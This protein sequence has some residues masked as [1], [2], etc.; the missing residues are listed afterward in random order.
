MRVVLVIPIFNEA[1]VLPQLLGRLEALRVRLSSHAL[2]VVFIDDGCRD[3]SA[4]L[5]AAHPGCIAPAPWLHL[6]RLSRNFG[7]Q[8]ALSAGLVHAATLAP[9][10]VVTLD[11]DLQDPP[12]VIPDLLDAHARGADVVLAVRR[13]RQERGLRRMGFDLFHKLFGSVVDQPVERNTGT[14]GLLSRDALDAFLQLRERH[15]FFPGLRSWIGFTRAEVA[16]D[17]QERAAGEPAVTFRKLVRYALDGVF[18]FSHLPLRLVTYAGLFSAGVG[19]AVAIFFA[20]KRLLGLES[21]FTGF[22]T[23]VTLVLFLGGVQLVAI[24]ILGEYLGRIYDE[25]KQR[26]HFIVRPK[27]PTDPSAPSA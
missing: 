11:A 17:R 22:T 13:S 7:H 14:F 16:Y 24:G 6:V 1:L 19:F 27:R 3:Q 2:E 9:D 5:V 8:A 10:V 18:S 23:L 25:V 12:E 21:A 4:A 15:R 20:A 26:P